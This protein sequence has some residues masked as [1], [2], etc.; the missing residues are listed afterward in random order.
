[1][2][3]RSCCPDV[4]DVMNQH[5]MGLLAPKETWI[6]DPTLELKALVK[7]SDRDLFKLVLVD[8]SCGPSPIKISIKSEKNIPESMLIADSKTCQL[9]AVSQA[10]LGTV[11]STGARTYTQL[12]SLAPRSSP[13][14]KTA[15]MSS[16]LV[17]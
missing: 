1:M 11:R 16:D 15:T 3:L 17:M 13:M 6:L 10:T 5:H 4:I 8:R 9:V 14:R 2:L 12:P 7:L